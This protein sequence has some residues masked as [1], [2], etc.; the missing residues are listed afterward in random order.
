MI[1]ESV[2]RKIKLET[3]TFR[4]KLALECL[5]RK[6]WTEN[7]NCRMKAFRE[8]IEKLPRVNL[9]HSSFLWRCIPEGMTKVEIVD[10]LS[11]LTVHRDEELRGWEFHWNLSFT[12]VSRNTSVSL[13]YQSR[14]VPKNLKV[15]FENCQRK[16]F[17]CGKFNLFLAE[18]RR[19]GLKKFCQVIT[20]AGNR[21]VGNTLFMCIASK[22]SV[23]MAAS[24]LLV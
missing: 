22:L 15:C 4:G 17:L 14:N 11:R 6:L 21:T 8:Q 19:T 18:S 2:K 5:C 13:S 1:V 7:V 23:N 20:L 24:G 3:F 16:R 12:L 10:V 9:I